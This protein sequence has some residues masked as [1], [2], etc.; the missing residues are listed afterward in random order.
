[1][2]SSSILIKRF[3]LCP[4]ERVPRVVGGDG[5]E[6]GIMTWWGGEVRG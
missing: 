1:M 6:M 5:G 4:V 3:L 2:R